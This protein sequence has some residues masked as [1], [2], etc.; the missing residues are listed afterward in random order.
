M[1]SERSRVELSGFVARN[2]DF[3]MN[4]LTF[5]GYTRLI[6]GAIKKMDLKKGDRILDFG[7][8]SGKNAILMLKRMNFDGEVV[9]VDISSE[10]LQNAMKRSKVYKNFKVFK[11]RIEEELPFNNEFDHI[12]M[13]FVFHGF[14]DYDKEKILKNAYRA[15]KNE[16]YLNILDYSEFNLE[17]SNFLVKWLFKKFECPLAFEFVELDLSKYVENFGFKTQKEIPLGFGYIRLFVAKKM[18]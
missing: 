11:G 12:F 16:G 17:K 13:S 15:L 5:G 4:L 18:R 3:L 9:G 2:Y 6:D 1:G 14:E 8:G 10:M 7:C